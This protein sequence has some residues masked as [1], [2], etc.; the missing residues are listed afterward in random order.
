MVALE[1]VYEARARLYQMTTSFVSYLSLKPMIFD[2]E[3]LQASRRRGLIPH[4]ISAW[5]NIV[6]VFLTA[7]N[8]Y[9]TVPTTNEYAEALNMDASYSGIIIGMSPVAQIFSAFVF[10]WWSNKA[11]KYPLIVSSVLQLIGQSF[12]LCIGYSINRPSVLLCSDLV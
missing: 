9:I 2:D 12:R 7:C 3:Q 1:D 10:S 5:L 4:Q 11:F 6:S 8:Y